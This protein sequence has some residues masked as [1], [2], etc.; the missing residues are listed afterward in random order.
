MT[1]GRG[2]ERRVGFLGFVAHEVR[3]PLATALWSAEL[4]ARL[5]AEERA[6]ARGEKLSAMCL[7]S[8]G[9]VRQLVEDHLLCERLDAGGVPTRPERVAVHALVQAVVEHAGL[10]AGV[11][12]I[13]PD[14][15]IESDRFLL[16]RALESLVAVAGADGS[17]FRVAARTDERN[18]AIVVSGRP[19]QP[20]ALLDP[21]KGATSDLKGRALALPLVRRIASALGGSLRAGESGY[22]FTLPHEQPDASASPEL[23]P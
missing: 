12:E 20:E 3:N 21:V 23:T 17:R 16:E 1:N 5:S 10:G 6:S 18:V 13:A 15:A 8:L 22:V 4:L 14:L 7:R 9:R 19:A 11:V 2:E